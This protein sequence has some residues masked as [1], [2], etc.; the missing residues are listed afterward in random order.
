M[1]VDTELRGA[2]RG[3]A[4]ILCRRADLLLQ[5]S[6]TGDYSS[7]VCL[8]SRI[9]D[10]SARQIVCMRK[11]QFVVHLEKYVYS[12]IKRR[13]RSTLAGRVKKLT[14]CK[15]PLVQ[16]SRWWCQH[17]LKLKT[18]KDHGNHETNNEQRL[19]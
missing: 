8:L 11:V 5:V 19:R 4:G 14:H 3:D 12:S 10:L 6:Q 7:V 18:T 9:K 16:Q 17:T 13:S 2:V 15:N 1:R